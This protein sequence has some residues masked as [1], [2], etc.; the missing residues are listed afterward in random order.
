M[1]KYP[2]INF[3]EGTISFWTKAENFKWDDN[4]KK[5]LFE[6]SKDNNKISI[7]KNKKNCLEVIYKVNGNKKRI[8]S[9]VEN[10]S[11][12]KRHYVVFTWSQPKKEIKI[13]LDGKELSKKKL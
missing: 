11:N 5:I 12:K 2:N 3:K 4:K 13:Y 8:S 1:Q 6:V 10:I 7:I 9:S